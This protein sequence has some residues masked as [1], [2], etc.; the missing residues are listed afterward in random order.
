MFFFHVDIGAATGGFL[1]RKFSEILNILENANFCRITDF[2]HRTDFFK[3]YYKKFVFLFKK[4]KHFPPAGAKLQRL[5][6]GMLQ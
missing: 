6:C 1:V 5:L 3:N 4:L 2:F